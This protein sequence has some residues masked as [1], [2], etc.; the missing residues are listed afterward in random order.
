MLAQLPRP[1]VGMSYIGVG[2][3]FGGDQC[4]PQ[5]HVHLEFLLGTLGG[6]GQCWQECQ[7]VSEVGNGFLMRA[8]LQGLLPSRVEI[9]DRPHHIASP[10]KMHRQFRR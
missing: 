2:V 6:L 7:G 4:R 8:P 5:G 1:A 10:R 9:A 3:P